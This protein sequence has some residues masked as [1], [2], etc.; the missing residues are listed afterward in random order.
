MARKRI[1]MQA[2]IAA[3]RVRQS[4]QSP[5]DYDK[6]VKQAN[7]AR[8]SNLVTDLNPQ[9]ISRVVAERLLEVFADATPFEE[10]GRTINRT[11]AAARI[12]KATLSP[13]DQLHTGAIA[14][15]VKSANE[16]LQAADTAMKT[17]QPRVRQRADA[18]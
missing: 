7:L 5:T 17:Y 14:L 15:G 2:A 13:N 18:R 10:N 4:T 16:A 8:E 12:A 1:D 9:S 3:H 6:H 11:Q